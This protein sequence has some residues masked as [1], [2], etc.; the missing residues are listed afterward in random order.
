MKLNKKEFI[1]S[2]SLKYLTQNK[3]KTTSFLCMEGVRVLCSQNVDE[4]IIFFFCIALSPNFAFGYKYSSSWP[5]MHAARK[6]IWN[7]GS[8]S[9]AWARSSLETI[10]SKK[11][12]TLF[13]EK[14]K[15]KGAAT[16]LRCPSPFYFLF[17]GHFFVS[18]SL[19]SR[20]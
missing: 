19:L 18:V 11:K 16:N 10:Y 20:T 15:I 7:R 2:Q 3:L 17:P 6:G 13:K 12:I 8:W 1:Y 5:T 14:K 4:T 9:H